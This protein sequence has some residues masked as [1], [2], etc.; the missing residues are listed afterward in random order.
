MSNCLFN[1]NPFKK[2]KL[3]FMKKCLLCYLLYFFEI[4]TYKAVKCSIVSSISNLHPE[5]GIQQIQIQKLIRVWKWFHDSCKEFWSL[6]EIRI[7]SKWKAIMNHYVVLLVNMVFF[8]VWSIKPAHV[9][10]VSCLVQTLPRSENFGVVMFLL[11]WPGGL[12]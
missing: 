2:H 12:V 1:Y 11:L 9:I 5:K 3:H 10:R 6:T 8:C 7:E 4:Y